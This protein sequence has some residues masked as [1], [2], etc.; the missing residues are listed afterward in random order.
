MLLH[1]NV[2]FFICL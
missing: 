1:A 2:E